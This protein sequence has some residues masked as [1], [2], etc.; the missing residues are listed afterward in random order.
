MNTHLDQLPP[1]GDILAAKQRFKFYAQRGLLKHAVPVAHGGRGDSF[2]QLV[3]AHIAVGQECQ[4]TGLVLSLNAHIW[5]AIFPLLIYGTPAQQQH[6]LPDL[7]NGQRIGGHAITEPDSGSDLNALTT[8]ASKTDTGFCLNGCKRYITNTPIA[9][10]LIVYAKFGQH[11]SAFMVKKDDVGAHFT[12]QTQVNGCATATMGDVTF[13]NCCI[14]NDRQLGT[15]DAGA[16]MI[17]T[18]LELERAFIFAGISGIMHWQLEQVIRYSRKRKVNAK[19][20]AHYQA[21]SHKIADMKVRLDTIRL[22][23]NECA[24]LKDERK[25]ITMVSAQTK[26]LASEAFLQSSLECI[27]IMGAH[28]LAVDNPLSQLVHD[29]MASRLFSGSSEIQRN[30]IAALL[31]VGDGL[32]T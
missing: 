20:L 16:L 27:Q 22:W 23:L 6:W 30:I 26:L 31:G 11:L 8:Y 3:Q 7:V 9:D 14:P 1:S 10:L 2:Q 12:H 5:G 19:H 18:A 15:I 24:R 17:Q 4:D 21:I 29:A 32:R 13:E 25:R 28:G